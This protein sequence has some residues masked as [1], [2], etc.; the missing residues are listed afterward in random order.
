[1]VNSIGLLEDGDLLVSSPG[2]PRFDKDGSSETESDPNR[3]GEDSDGEDDTEEVGPTYREGSHNPLDI[4]ITGLNQSGANLYGS[5]DPAS[6]KR[7]STLLRASSVESICEPKC[8]K[9][10]E[11]V[12]GALLGKFRLDESKMV[13]LGPAT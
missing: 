8:C 10:I 3:D 9:V 2:H 12:M 5:G 4:L 1:M 11:D 13:K 7:A 6:R